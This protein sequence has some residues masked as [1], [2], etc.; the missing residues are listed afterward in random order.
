[1]ITSDVLAPALALPADQGFHL[2]PKRKMRRYFG[3]W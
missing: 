1:M 2:K 3:R